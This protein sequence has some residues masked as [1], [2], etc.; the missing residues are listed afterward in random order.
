MEV[1]CTFPEGLLILAANLSLL[2][3]TV[4]SPVY[5]NNNKLKYKSLPVCFLMIIQWQRWKCLSKKEE[6]P[7][8]NDS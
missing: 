2:S 6:M 1:D 7:S 4:L 8:L 5:L 3:V